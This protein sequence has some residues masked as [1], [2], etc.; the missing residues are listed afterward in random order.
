[1]SAFNQYLGVGVCG[2][3]CHC[4][5]GRRRGLLPHNVRLWCEALGAGGDVLSVEPALVFGRADKFEAVSHLRSR[6]SGLMVDG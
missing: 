4:R 2:G 1:M 6:N 3:R 5:L